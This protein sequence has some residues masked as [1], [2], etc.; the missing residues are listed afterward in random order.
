MKKYLISSFI[1]LSLWGCSKNKD[2]SS[3]SNSN[4]LSITTVTPI[5]KEAS[6]AGLEATASLMDQLTNDGNL[7][8][9][10]N[11]ADAQDALEGF[12]GDTFGG[13]S[14]TSTTGQIFS[15]IADLDYRIAEIN[16]RFQSN[17]PG[18]LDNDLVPV[19]KGLSAL[20]HTIDLKFSCSDN[21]SGGVAGTGSGMLWGQEGDITYLGLLLVQSNNID[22]FGYFAKINTA[23]RAV[24][25]IFMEYFPTNLR[26]S[27]THLRTD[28]SNSKYELVY[29]SAGGSA[30]PSQPA[31]SVP[32]A[33]GVR[34]ITSSTQVF[35]EGTAASTSSTGTVNGTS[36]TFSNE[37]FNASDL[38]AITSLCTDLS[39]TSFDADM[40]L[41]TASQVYSESANIQSQLTIDIPG[42]SAATTN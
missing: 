12:F 37:C 42:V 40:S 14:G 13:I 26:N 19:T 41:F 20:G 16:Q 1:L 6:P 30:G 31:G 24:D 17:R 2:S 7:S 28:A 10:S 38:A 25:L 29:A 27:F 15:Y 9:K 18:C 22:K 21:F 34:L 8:T 35:V 23:T 32:L 36:Y 5:I 3:S 33:A 4:S 11:D 39:S